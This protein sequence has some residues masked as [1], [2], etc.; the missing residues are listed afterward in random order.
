[1]MK[2]MIPMGAVANDPPLAD[3]PLSHR[4][5]WVSVESPGQQ[6]AYEVTD[7]QGN[8]EAEE[9]ALDVYD[10]FHFEV[11]FDR[12]LHPNETPVIKLHELYPAAE[13][14][15]P[16]TMTLF[17][18]DGHR[19]GEPRSFHPIRSVED[20]EERLYQFHVGFNTFHEKRF[21]D[22]ADISGVEFCVLNT[23]VN[24]ERPELDPTWELRVDDDY[25]LRHTVPNCRG[26]GAQCPMNAVY[27]RNTTPDQWAQNDPAWYFWR[28]GRM[29]KDPATGIYYLLD[30]EEY[31]EHGGSEKLTRT[32]GSGASK[33]V[34]IFAN[35]G[36]KRFVS[37]ARVRLGSRLENP[38]RAAYCIANADAVTRESGWIDRAER[39]EGYRPEVGMSP[40]G[41]ISDPSV[42]W[43]SVYAGRQKKWLAEWKE[44]GMSPKQIE[45]LATDL[46]NRGLLEIKVTNGMKEYRGKVTYFDEADMKDYYIG[47]VTW[48]MMVDD[49][50]WT[51]LVKFNFRSGELRSYMIFRDFERERKML[52]T[53]KHVADLMKNDGI[54]MA[55]AAKSAPA[56][57]MQ[58][59]LWGSAKWYNENVDTC[60]IKLDTWRDPRVAGLFKWRKKV[61][62]SLKEGAST[63]MKDRLAK[64]LAAVAPRDEQP[65]RMQPEEM[66]EALTR[67]LSK[68]KAVSVEAPK[69]LLRV[70]VITCDDDM[71]EDAP[72]DEP[73]DQKRRRVEDTHM[74]V[75]RLLERGSSAAQL[76][77]AIFNAIGALTLLRK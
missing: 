28:K 42:T 26:M 73:P 49:L 4:R 22:G 9:D 51:R 41:L 37:S 20:A 24:H 65:A 74:D 10:T 68:R 38:V 6:L 19:D 55:L 12:P 7:L 53:M 57:A 76:N 33:G 40:D 14:K 2:V 75:L 11:R 48:N 66:R 60:S 25:Y 21:G 3:T 45:A 52:A 46:P 44:Q 58:K 31:E 17:K 1:M 8:H 67:H 70:P 54:D 62:Q 59:K 43:D 35:Y 36:D 18:L 50:Y 39:F 77:E 13:G 71:V 64:R 56:K 34:G 69:K 29:I 72:T 47:Q 27:L 61:R 16:R 5:F 23:H 63:S 15:K 32:G 30:D